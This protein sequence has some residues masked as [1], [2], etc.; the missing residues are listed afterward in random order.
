MRVLL[1]VDY[2]DNTGK[3]WFDS[4]IKNMPVEFDETKESIHKVIERECEEE[5]MELSYKGKPQSTMYNKVGEP[6]GYVY[7]G[8]SEIQD[9]NMIKSVVALF[10][11]WVSIKT[12]SDFKIEELHK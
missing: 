2:R 11:V 9:R 3:W 6:I 4:Y 12:I 7:R 1:N 8:K 10:D 5:G